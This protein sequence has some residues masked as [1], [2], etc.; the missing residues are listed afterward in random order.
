M[1]EEELEDGRRV[2][3]GPEVNGSGWLKLTYSPADEKM[4]MQ[5]TGRR[6]NP[7]NFTCMGISRTQW[8]G[9]ARCSSRAEWFQEAD[10]LAR[11]AK[12]E[13]RGYFMT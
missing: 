2:M 6:E 7:K 13:S 3:S 5:I 4:L 12:S 1:L 8:A 10:R 11:D 9:L